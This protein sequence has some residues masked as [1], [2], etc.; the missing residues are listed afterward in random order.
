[1][2]EREYPKKAQINPI[3]PNEFV[4][5]KVN[6]PDEQTDD[7]IL[8]NTRLVP[9]E[10]NNKSISNYS[11]FSYYITRNY[12]SKIRFNEAIKKYEDATR[13]KSL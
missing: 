5:T 7:N 3:I 9:G 11:S 2:R 6:S 4:A 10:I 13:K 8:V 1:M 12:N